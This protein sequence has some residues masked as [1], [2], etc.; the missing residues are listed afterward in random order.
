MFS[1]VLAFFV[2]VAFVLQNKNKNKKKEKKTKNTR[3]LRAL[4]VIDD[5]NYKRDSK[6][7]ACIKCKSIGIVVNAV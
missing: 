7:P 1:C 4:N 2:V 5:N 6:K 3:H